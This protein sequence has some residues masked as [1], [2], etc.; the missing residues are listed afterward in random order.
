VTSALLASELPQH[1]KI[2]SSGAIYLMSSHSFITLPPDNRVTSISEGLR[3]FALI[4][5]GTCAVELFW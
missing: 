2:G 3:F 5:G 1:A 4:D